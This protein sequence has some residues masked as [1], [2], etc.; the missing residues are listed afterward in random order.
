MMDAMKN[1]KVQKAKLHAYRDNAPWI[2]YSPTDDVFKHP[3]N[4]PFRDY[5]VLVRYT[6]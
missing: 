4:R 1:K 3:K 2:P 5:K 6:F